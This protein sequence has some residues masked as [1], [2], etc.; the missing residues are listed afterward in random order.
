MFFKSI[1]LS[2][3]WRLLLLI[4][5]I[6][7]SPFPRLHSIVHFMRTIGSSAIH[8]FNRPL[9]PQVMWFVG[10]GESTKVPLSRCM[11]NEN[12]PIGGVK[13]GLAV[14]GAPTTRLGVLLLLIRSLRVVLLDGGGL[15]LLV[16]FLSGWI[17]IM[18]HK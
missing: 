3:C 2:P 13:A 12:L 18:W 6:H 10:G 8:S 17:I 15:V 11:G 1:N 5:I 7:F 4:R 16:W 14:A 9:K